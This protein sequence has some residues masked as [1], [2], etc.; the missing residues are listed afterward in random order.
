MELGLKDKVVLITG[1]TR[2]IGADIARGFAEEGARVA[3]CART[4]ADLEARSTEIARATGATVIGVPV[5]LSRRGEPE[6]LVEQVVSRFG[7]LDV[8][9]N[10]AGVAPGGNIEELTDDDWERGIQLKLL[11]LV[12]CT[13]AAIPVMRKQGG[14]RVVNV[15][16]NDGVKC[17]YWEIVPAICCAAELIFTA[18]LAEEYG[19]EGIYVNAV[20]PGPVETGL[21][22]GLFEQV[23]KRRGLSVEEVVDAHVESIPLKLGRIAKPREV[24]DVVL[25]LASDRASFVNGVSVNVDGG[26]MK[27]VLAR[28]VYGRGRRAR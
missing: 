24:T 23:A 21:M 4:Q 14:G 3:I 12:R 27:P 8:L 7:R 9:V 18:T 19:P 2:G 16:G 6:R 1:G 10:S 15:V 20:N 11:G 13:R 17:A 25:F 22:R 28:L 5:D 26:Q